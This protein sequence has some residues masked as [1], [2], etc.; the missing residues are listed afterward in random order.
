WDAKVDRAPILALTGQVQT[1]VLGPGAFEELPLAS[2]FDAVAEWSQTVLRP[3][4]AT[5][6]AALAMKHAI[7]NRDVAHLILPDEVQELPGLD[8]PPPRPREG[9]IAS[10]EVLP[11]TPE[12]DRAA[13]MLR[14]AERP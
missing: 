11:P 1:Q 3:A 7:V 9:R 13:E 14:V 8:E 12:L 2:A 10:A 6:L 4:N 5:E